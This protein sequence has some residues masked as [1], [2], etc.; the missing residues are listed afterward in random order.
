MRYFSFI[1]TIGF[2]LILFE[3]SLF[4]F[5]KIGDL[6]INLIFPFIVWIAFSKN[7]EHGLFYVIGIAFIVEIFTIISPYVYILSFTLSYLLVK[8]ILD[9]INCVFI[10]QRM[11]IVGLVT[12]LSNFIMYLFYGVLDRVIPFGMLQA[13]INAILTPFLFLLYDKINFFFFPEFMDKTPE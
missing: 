7:I 1:L 10:W 5:I 4:S 9:N 8:Y 13:I 11:L 2:I 12:L 6:K 3:T